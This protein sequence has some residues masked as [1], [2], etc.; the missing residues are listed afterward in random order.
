MANQEAIKKYQDELKSLKDTLTKYGDLFNSDGTIDAKEQQQLDTMHDIIKKAEAKLAEMQKETVVRDAKNPDPLAKDAKVD[1]K[2][3]TTQKANRVATLFSTG[4]DPMDGNKD[5]NSVSD[6][7]VDQGGLGD[8]YFL[9]ALAAVAKS[10]PQAIKNLISG[11]DANGNYQVKLYVSKTDLWVVNWRTY[12]TVTITPEFLVDASGNPIYA[13]KGDGELWVMLIE[14]AYAILRGKVKPGKVGYTGLEGG[15]GD[16]GIEVLTGVEADRIP[17]SA[18]P[19]KDVADKIMAALTNKKA[20]T[21]GTYSAFSKAMN[22][23]MIKG[24]F[25]IHASHEYYIASAT[26]SKITV[27]NPHNSARDG[28]REVVLSI[29]DYKMF[30]E[31]FSVQ[32]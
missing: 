30:F 21:T 24:K 7:D 4:T 8:C 1:L 14:K 6:N 29:A 22:E 28:G 9:S 27:R 32:Q 11:P 20:I 10:N 13:G 26:S 16:E 12:E 17:I 31:D 2:N 15:F 23:R 18:M 19:D 25:T 5:A 3:V